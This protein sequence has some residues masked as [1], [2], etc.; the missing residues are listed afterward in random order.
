VYFFKMTPEPTALLPATKPRAE[1]QLG[2]LAARILHGLEADKTRKLH[3]PLPS[4]RNLAR[5]FGAS[6]NT[7]QR[8]L[9]TLSARGAAYGLP[10]KG[11]YWGKGPAPPPTLPQR[12]ADGPKGIAEALKEDLRAGALD[13]FTRLPAQ[14]ALADR[15][16]V[17]TRTV[18][19][20]LLALEADEV[21]DRRGRTYRFKAG[22][23]AAPGSLVILVTRCDI[24]GRFLLDSERELDFL[25]AAYMETRALRLEL[26]VIG[27]GPGG[28]LLD[29]QGRKIP[30]T[31]AG[32]P[33]LGFLVSTWLIPDI[34][35]ILALLRPYHLPVSIWWEHSSESLSKTR[36]PR[37][38]VFFNLSFGERPGA[39]IAETLLGMGHTQVL[40]LSPFHASPWSQQR[41]E[42]LRN[43]ILKAPGGRV[44]AV[45]DDSH[46]S[47][48]SF[49]EEAWKELRAE[50]RALA[51]DAPQVMR[52]KNRNLARRVRVMLEGAPPAPDAT[53]WV[54]VNDETAEIASAYI[55]TRDKKTT[56]NATRDK[57][58]APYL[59]SFDNSA[60][61]Y[62]LGIDSF[63][64]DSGAM[65][66]KMLFHL[67]RPSASVFPGRG[68]ID[69]DGRVERK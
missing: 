61:S 47:P 9:R 4:I 45:T 14:K 55:R 46:A 56:D 21:L 20:A 33:V 59:I 26:K 31:P 53:A 60:A 37:N 32:R 67:T 69:L 10:G 25:K 2:G 29:R 23:P 8:A 35:G 64:F 28:R 24:S 7:V 17:S 66:R 27:F 52:R 19:K 58:P 51:A 63:A 48:W 39:L 43:R 22:P 41:L 68:L 38:V 12:K 16:H 1:A 57:Q 36:F 6:V 50:N 13:P 3:A 18:R 11:Y 5:H 49:Q 44:T 30:P 62:R 15:Y 34:H 54:C 42:G 65:A 40:F